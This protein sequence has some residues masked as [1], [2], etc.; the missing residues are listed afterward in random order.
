MRELY[1]NGRCVKYTWDGELK[2]IVR[3]E[4]ARQRERVVPGY[5]ERGRAPPTP[6]QLKKQIAT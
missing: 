3:R 6:I 4:L 5:R 1:L 2:M